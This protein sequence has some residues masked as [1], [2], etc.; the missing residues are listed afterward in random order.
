MGKK[1][2]LEDIDDALKLSANDKAPSLDGIC[3]E[4]WKLLHAHY[5][6]AW[7]H[8][9]PAF[10]IVQTLIWVYNDIETHGMAR[11]TRFSESWMCPL[12]LKNDQSQMANYHPISLLNTDY[13]VMTKAVLV[14]L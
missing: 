5:K 7:A 2:L 8:Q 9:K 4:I 6:N 11:N 12:Y 10:I 3:D 1:L 14:D 13:K